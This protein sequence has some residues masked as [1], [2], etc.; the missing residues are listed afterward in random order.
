M[1]GEGGEGERDRLKKAAE[2]TEKEAEGG[3][4]KKAAG[5]TEK[6]ARTEREDGGRGT[7]IVSAA[8]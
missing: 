4:L 6:E 1:D 8:K 5:W 3:R 7:R 2:W